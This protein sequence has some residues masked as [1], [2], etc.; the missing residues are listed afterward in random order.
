M[1]TTTPGIWYH[2][3][4]VISLVSF[5]LAV[6]VVGYFIAKLGY[7]LLVKGVTGEFKFRTE[8]KGTKADLVSASPGIFFIAMATIMIAIAII[9]D[10]PFE[11]TVTQRK[12]ESSAEQMIEKEV[13]NT[14][15]TAPSKVP[16]D[17]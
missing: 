14:K 2:A 4:T 17:N 11:T 15:P 5:K 12:V 6:L 16:G 9:K 7:Q 8:F 13:P 10:K 3:I 1:D